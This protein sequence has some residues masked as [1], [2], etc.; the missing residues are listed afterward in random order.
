M[1]DPIRVIIA[2]DHPIVRSGLRREIEHD[3]GCV[4]VGEAGDGVAA[5]ALIRSAGPD[6]AVIDLD[7]PQLDGFGVARAVTAER[8]GVALVFLTLH[9]QE[10]MFH[11]AMQLARRARLHPE[12]QRGRR[13]RVDTLT[14]CFDASL[15]SREQIADAPDRA[16]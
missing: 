6:V 14:A 11:G 2:D 4:V 3:P 5:L 16:G 15:Y 1:A 9:N 8:I 7:M 13:G 10:D 12:G